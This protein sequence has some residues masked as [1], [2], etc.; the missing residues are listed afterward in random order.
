M[1]NKIS[2]KEKDKLGKTSSDNNTYRAYNYF[3]QKG[4]T[5]AQAS[6]L[7]GNLAQESGLALNTRVE[8]FDKTGS[9]GIAQWLGN[10]KENLVKFAT[11]QD[12]S[13][14]DFNTQLDFVWHELNTSENKAFNKLKESKT[15]EQAAQAISKY[16]ER[17]H[18]DYAHN[19]KR[20]KYANQFYSQYTGENVPSSVIQ[21]DNIDMN[22][23]DYNTPTVSVPNINNPDKDK[24]LQDY[25]NYLGQKK[26]DE[27]RQ[28]QKVKEQDYKSEL[29]RKID[30]RAFISEYLG[31]TDVE[32]I[33]RKTTDNELLT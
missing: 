1:D 27:I 10:R 2:W 13:H 21:D 18:K 4:L 22:P 8:G 17:P 7:V 15:P 3:V 19:E 31:S 12:K 23:I 25:E 5:P 26:E 24:F 32:Y 14:S 28:E 33:E 20:V 11:K 30:E 9:Y 6:G 29:Q 16:Y